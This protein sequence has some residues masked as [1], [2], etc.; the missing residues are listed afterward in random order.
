MRTLASGWAHRPGAGLQLTRMAQAAALVDGPGHA[1]PDDVK[2]LAG[3]VLAHR[4]L[5]EP[6]GPTPAE[7]VS[8]VL[9]QTP[10]GG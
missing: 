4:I 1:L 7:V 8:R 2:R 9:V 10:V 6:G 5:T 3:A